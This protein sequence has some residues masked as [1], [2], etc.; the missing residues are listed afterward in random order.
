MNKTAAHYSFFV[1]LLAAPALQA[2]TYH[3]NVVIVL[4]ASGSMRGALT[5]TGL[6]KIDGAKAALKEVVQKLPDSTYVGLLVF[7]AGN[8]TNDWAF[9]LGPRD[10]VQLVRAIDMPEPRQGTPLGR[11]IK[12]GADRLLEERAK[13]F[14]YG[15][16]RL[17]VVT[18]GEAED[19]KLVDR[20]TPEV[21]ARGITM[22][23]IGVGMNRRHTLATKVHSYRAAND[24][25]SLK[26]AL[27]EVFAEVSSPGGDNPMEDVFTQIAGLPSE[28]AAAAIQTLA[29]TGNTPIGEKSVAP[30][31]SRTAPRS[32]AKPV[33]SGQAAPAQSISP[34]PAPP[35][36]VSQRKRMPVWLMILVPVVIVLFIIKPKGKSRP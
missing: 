10:N 6:S 27:Q 28:V 16:Y 25:G 32:S 24:P 11:Y 17:L 12:K 19:A 36:P 3:D 2:Q 29:A 8:L 23:V 9:P 35:P 4:D 26:K 34:R 13:Q 20:Y 7:S 14:G 33:T 21:I 1:A 15:T 5:G 18:D 31:A 30:N 22:D